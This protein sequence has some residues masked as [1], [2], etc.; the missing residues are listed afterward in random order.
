MKPSLLQYKINIE[1]ALLQG[2]YWALYSILLSFSSV[3]LLHKG[4]TNSQIGIILAVGFLA[5]VLLQQYI[6][7]W[8]DRTRR[9]TLPVITAI[10]VLCLTLCCIGL[11]FCQSSSVY[12]TLIFITACILEMLIQPLV[13]SLN[14]Y[15]QQIPVKMNFGVARSIGSLFYSGTCLLLGIMIER[16]NPDIL[17][18][19]GI[20]VCICVILLLLMMNYD[21]CKNTQYSPKDTSPVE[22]SVGIREF[23][24]Q[25]RMFFVFLIGGL[26]LYFGHTL[27][28]NYFYQIII[29]IHGSSQDLGNI[30]AFSALLELPAMIFFSM[31]H[32]KFGCRKLLQASA[33]FF[34]IK[35][36][37]TLFATNIPMLYVSMLFQS[38]S[39]AIFIPASVHLVN[40]VMFPKDAVK[41]Q[42]FVTGMITIANLLSS[43]LGGML[44]D[45]SNVF[46]M[47][48]VGTITTV[49]GAG[50]AI[51]SLRQSNTIR[52][53]QQI[54]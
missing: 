35:I 9:L 1:Y 17:P 48:L 25:Y 41:G 8:A 31:L 22:E 47:L 26:G 45:H 3:Y 6:A 21:S 43:L 39:F 34:V 13:N 28:N 38:L 16:K 50:I 32:S 33:F 30:Q 18:A 27:I 46:F 54:D 20:F 10:C 4:Y 44:L 53:K 37:L 23:F 24:I 12:H 52:K 49:L 15:L 36:I 51:V 40:E 42:A 5:S 7:A 29:N 19:Y 2:F 11:L 14:F